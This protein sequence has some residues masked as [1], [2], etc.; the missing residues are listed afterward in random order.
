MLIRSLPFVAGVVPFVAINVAFWIGVTWG[1]LPS[2]IPYIDG[3]T[4]ISATGRYPPGSFLFKAVEMPLSVL[5]IVIWGY[6]VAWLK[7]LQPPLDNRRATWILAW[8]II[9]GISLL[10]YVTFLG[11]KEPFYEFMRRFG[12]YFYFLG[13]AVAQIFVSLHAHAV[14]AGRPELRRAS[15]TML[16]LC[17]LPFGLGILNL[18]LKELLADPD[19]MENRIE[20]IAASVMQGWFVALWAA[21]R[22]TGF[23]ATVSVDSTSARS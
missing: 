23:E 10:V 15:T 4:S 7:Q 2:C 5:L 22:R 21:W 6:A 3:C 1:P 16:W 12:I 17:L 19:P 13:T 20:W 8:G 14:A 11:T 9:G 18:V